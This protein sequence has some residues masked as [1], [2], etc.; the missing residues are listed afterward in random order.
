ML[1]VDFTWTRNKDPRVP[2]GHASLLAALHTEATLEVRSLVVAV[3]TPHCRPHSVVSR[4]LMETSD[5][6]PSAIDVA[7]GAYVWGEDTLTA[8]LRGL[9]ARGFQGRIIVGGPQ[10][11][12][13]GAG[14]DGL[15]PEAD[16][17]IR[18]YGE[19]ALRQLARSPERQAITGVHFR[20][21]ADV[22][23]QA[24]VDLEKLPSP[25]LSDLIPIAEGSFVRWET[26][27]GCPFR[28]GFCQHREAG[29]RLLRRSLGLP[30]I[31][32]EIDLFCRAGV[33]EIAVLDPIFNAGPHAVGVLQRFVDHGFA[34]RLALQCRAE[35]VTTEFLDVAGQ[36]NVCLE[37]G[38]QTIHTDEGRA[39][40]RGNNVARVDETFAAVRARG[41]QHEV[42]LIFGLPHQTL[43]SFKASVDW[44][45]ARRVPVL[46]AFPLMLLR[47]TE[48][49]RERE[50]WDLVDT[51]GAMPMVI[52]SSSFTRDEWEVMAQLAEA[53][54][55]TEEHHPLSVAELEEMAHALTPDLF[56][57]LPSGKKEAA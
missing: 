1:L 21:E 23:A 29:A 40:R 16:V 45:L 43:A 10:I 17:F 14:I 20:G 24:S 15:Y 30:R 5:C 7:F 31:E 4:I 12:Y 13:S 3:N 39:V 54:S 47:G 38:L 36:L 55:G 37:F 28:C 53:L 27:R 49:E 9:R 50:K 18:G 56:R 11:S 46:K 8:V 19:Q 57:W 51:G 41:I 26:Q 34:G 2:L 22:V 6:L 33:G 52:E 48:L 42:S 35:T 44:C 32:A 25:W